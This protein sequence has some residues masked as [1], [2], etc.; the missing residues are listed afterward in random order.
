MQKHHAVRTSQ[1]RATVIACVL[2]RQTQINPDE[3]SPVDALLKQLLHAEGTRSGGRAGSRPVPMTNRSWEAL[4][5]SCSAKLIVIN[6]SC[7]SRSSQPCRSMSVGT[8]GHF[9]GTSARCIMRHTV[10]WACLRGC[11]LGHAAAQGNAVGDVTASWS[12]LER[13]F[14]IIHLLV[15]PKAWC[16]EDPPT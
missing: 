12:S 7:T 9:C 10:I 15:L 16:T 1:A 4:T 14:C 2:P 8:S 3:L 5:G 13:L 6:I 11:Y